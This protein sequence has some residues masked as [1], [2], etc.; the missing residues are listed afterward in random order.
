[1]LETIDCFDWRASRYQRSGAL[2]T[3]VSRLVL[4]KDVTYE[5]HLFRVANVVPNI[6]CATAELAAAIPAATCTGIKL[7]PPKQW[8]NPIG[9]R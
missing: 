3:Y 4:R 8:V 7:V 1:L 9:V 6:F 2:A 5:Q